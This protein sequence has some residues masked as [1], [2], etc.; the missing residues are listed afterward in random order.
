MLLQSCYMFISKV[1]IKFIIGFRDSVH[2]YQK[3]WNLLK[4]GIWKSVI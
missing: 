2:I 4:V 3:P 1:V